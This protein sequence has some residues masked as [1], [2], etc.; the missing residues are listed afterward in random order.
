M[1]NDGNNTV[2]DGATL[3]MGWRPIV[4]HH[5]RWRVATACKV[6]LVGRVGLHGLVGDAPGA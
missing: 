6:V 2:I 4:K 5:G 3:N 1:M